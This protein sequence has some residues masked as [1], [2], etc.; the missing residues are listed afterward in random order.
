MV[1]SLYVMCVVWLNFTRCCAWLE[2][3][4]QSSFTPPSSCDLYRSVCGLL[5]FV[6]CDLT[7]FFQFMYFFLF[8]FVFP[9]ILPHRLFPILFT[10][11][12]VTQDDPTLETKRLYSP[13]SDFNAPLIDW[14]VKGT[15]CREMRSQ[16][17]GLQ[18][19][20]KDGF[21]M[22]YFFFSFFFWNS[23]LVFLCT[24]DVSLK[25]ARLCKFCL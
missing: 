12:D 20:D 2:E 7:C 10:V 22:S 11:I 24:I 5:P 18:M 14:G 13:S 1:V 19:T 9:L 6:F 16:Q 21:C 15:A 4:V 17:L 25:G 23:V 8:C 3:I